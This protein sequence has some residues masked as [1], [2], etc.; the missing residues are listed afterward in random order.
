MQTDT[1]DGGQGA[2]RRRR[3]VRTAWLL[4]AFALFVAVSSVPFWKG[5]F[6]MAMGSG[7]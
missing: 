2:E 5:L 1:L 7:Q 6:Q 4:A 3:N